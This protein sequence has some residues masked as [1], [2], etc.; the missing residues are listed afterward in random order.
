M[1][2]L[3]ALSRIFVGVLF[4]ISGLIKLN[5]P[6]GFSYKL[7]E[8]F[9]ADVLNIE[10]LIP[11][12]LGI[13]VIVVVFEVVLGVFLL[14]GYKPKFTVWSLLAMIVF[15]TFLTFYSAYFDKVKDCGCFGDALKL[16]PWES[17][18][19]D[20]ILLF[21]ILILFF[22]LNHIKP[23][24][25]KLPT[26]ILALLSFIFSLWFGYHVLMH[27]PTIDFRAY[28]IGNNIAEGMRIPDDAPKAIQEFTWTFNINGEETEIVTDGSYPTVDGEYVGVE[29]KVIREAYQ[30]PVLDFSI[31]T[32]EE[33]L[34]EHFL[35]QE[36][37]IVIV[38]YSLEKMEQEG[39]LKLKSTTDEALK[40]GYQVIGL[41]A[42]GNDA[43]QRINEIYN[44]N[45]DWYLCDEKALKTVVR[46]NPGILE[47]DAGTVMQKVH[48]NDIED[49]QL[50]KVERKIESKKEN[51]E[52]KN[53]LYVVEGEVSTKEKLDSVL[54]SKNYK[55]YLYTIDETVLDS[56]NKANNSNYDGFMTVELHKE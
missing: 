12:A 52:I 2:T 10:F 43:K 3:V 9:G 28:K 4:I 48:W 40:N 32:D 16:T 33:D 31:E 27:L 45:F 1:K 15:F 21:F 23:V 6:L 38:S 17:F 55:N 53:I 26:T 34:T 51:A 39:A 46:S 56:I 36:N 47:L 19:K 37:L 22:G 24:F 29:T 35:S 20:V 44:L 42:S 25:S 14:I 49:L 18:T 5:D 11:Y 8:Y 54:A 13:S 30:P 7:E 41:T 50:P